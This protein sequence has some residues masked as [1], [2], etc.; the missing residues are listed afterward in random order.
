MRESASEKESDVRRPCQRPRRRSSRREG[1]G[2]GGAGGGGEE[3][4]KEGKVDRRGR[5]CRLRRNAAATQTA[6]PTAPR[7]LG[8]QRRRRGVPLR[9]YERDIQELQ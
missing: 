7:L 5:G 1:E 3:E 4:K 8:F 9:G 6:V 2:R